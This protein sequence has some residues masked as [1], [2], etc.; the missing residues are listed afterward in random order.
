MKVIIA[1]S[2]DI[3]D[4]ECVF[5]YIEEGLEFLGIEE[6]SC[7]V[8]GLAKGVDMLGKRWAESKGI[9][10]A[11][12]PADWEKHG[13]SAGY[14]RNSEMA[15]YGDVLIAIT[16]GSRGTGHMIDLSR[17]KGLKVY[18]KRYTKVE[19]EVDWLLGEE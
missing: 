1:G 2:R 5:K 16:N 15:D 12:F 7:V 4:R 17:K 19:E 13:K 11:E 9:E 3:V 10:V 18:V 6:V 8:C 14:I